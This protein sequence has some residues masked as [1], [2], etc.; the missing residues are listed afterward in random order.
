MEKAIYYYFYGYKYD[1]E[2]PCY[3]IACLGPELSLD[4]GASAETEMIIPPP[5]ATSTRTIITSTGK[6]G[7][8]VRL[9]QATFLVTPTRTGE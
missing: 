7:R 1:T 4:N 5:G 3:P 9:L 6:S 8:T 2:K